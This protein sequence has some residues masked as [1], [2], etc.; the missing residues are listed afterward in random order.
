MSS[1]SASPADESE[2]AVT[3]ETK[4]WEADWR[5]LLKRGGLERMIGSETFPFHTRSLYVNNV[6]SP[7]EVLKA[8]N[9]LVSRGILD[10]AELVEEHANDALDMANLGAGDLGRGY[11]YSIAELVGLLLAETPYLV[12][13]A[14][15]CK[16]TDGAP[17]I[18]DGV[19]LLSETSTVAVVSPRD[20]P[21][22]TEFKRDV[23]QAADRWY[24]DSGFS[25]QCYLIRTGDFTAPIYGFSHPD[26]AMYP[27]YGGELFEKR[28][29]SWLRCTDRHRAIYLGASYEH[30]RYGYLTATQ[31][32]VRSVKFRA[33]RRRS[34]ASSDTDSVGTG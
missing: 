13:F 18:A 15:D 19:T 30:Q 27:S 32:A 11:K 21:V 7:R 6:D 26:S 16:I 3:F 33:A 8:A 4:C 23:D 25:D 29:Y 5:F 17:W 34:M 2:A 24:F 14:G 12:H 28:V 1:V 9:R 10:R 22:S 20:S 31:R